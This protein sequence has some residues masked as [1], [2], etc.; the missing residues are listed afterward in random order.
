MVSRGCYV[1]NG[2]TFATDHVNNVAADFAQSITATLCIKYT[3][4]A[5]DDAVVIVVALSS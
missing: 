3:I 5:I 1:L 4:V 2:S